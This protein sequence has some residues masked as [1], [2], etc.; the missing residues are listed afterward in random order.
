ML[1]SAPFYSYFRIKIR[2]W[3]GANSKPGGGGISLSK[4]VAIE[5][6]LA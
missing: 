1:L 4:V 6:S 2:K 3:R 5:G